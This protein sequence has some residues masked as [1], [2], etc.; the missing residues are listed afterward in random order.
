M[1]HLNISMLYYTKNVVIA[2]PFTDE[3]GHH[4]N[5]CLVFPDEMGQIQYP[6]G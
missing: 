1:G 5:Q 3:T 4:Q 2:T 6:T